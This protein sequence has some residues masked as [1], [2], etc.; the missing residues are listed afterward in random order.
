MEKAKP[1]SFLIIFGSIFSLVGIC[2]LV[3]SFYSYNQTQKFISSSVSTTGTV[4]E[5]RLSVSDRSR[6]YYPTIKFKTQQGE[7]IETELNVGSNPP[8]HTVGEQVTI[9]YDPNNPRD[10]NVNSFLSL[11]FVAVVLLGLGGTFTTVGLGVLIA[12]LAYTLAANK[13]VELLKQNGT[14]IMTKI[15]GVDLNDSF[16]MNGASPYQITSQWLD[17]VTNEVHIFNSEHIWFDPQDFIKSEQVYVYVDP[18]N[19]ENYYMDISFLP[20][21]AKQ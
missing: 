8:E 10:A 17:P 9:L 20:K 21:L 13:K 11:Y 2:M 3:G 18:T 16:T 15:I 4:S 14:R 1:D 5:L 7:T 19:K 6:V 12:P